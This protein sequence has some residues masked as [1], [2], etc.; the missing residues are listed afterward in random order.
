MGVF[1]S[2][3]GDSDVLKVHNRID[4]VGAIE[5]IPLCSCVVNL[6]EIECVINWVHNYLK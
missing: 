3:D 2:R 1:L 6:E 4:L 5:T